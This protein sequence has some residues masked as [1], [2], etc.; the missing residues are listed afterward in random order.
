MSTVE[1]ALSLLAHFTAERPD[2]GLSE[3]CRLAGRDKATTYRH[4]EALETAGLLEQNPDS[5]L[6]RVGPA[7]IRLARL[8]ELTTP[9]VAILEDE[10]PNLAAATGETAHASLLEGSRLVA[11]AHRES[12]RHS[13]RVVVDVSEL[14]LHATASGLA[15]LAFGP[16]TLRSAALRRLDRF[17]DT[18]PKDAEELDAALSAARA[19]GVAVSPGSFEDDVHGFAVPL[20]DETGRVSGALAVAALAARVTPELADEIACQLARAGEQ[21]T[22]RWGGQVPDRL[23]ETWAAL[24]ASSRE[25]AA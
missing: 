1:K 3:L 17:T 21:V 9:R 14:P 16:P 12:P 8:R 4:L 10:L 15:V 6:Y 13:T 19:K 25:T 11:L 23:S 2:L 18:T 7:V 5:R 20:F 22:R 24:T